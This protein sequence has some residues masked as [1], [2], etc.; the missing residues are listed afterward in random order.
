MNRYGKLAASFLSFALAGVPAAH[1]VNI[2]FTGNFNADD[3]VQLFNFSTDGASTVFLVSYGW[4]GGTQADGNVVSA[5]GLDTILTL[6]DA[7][8]NY[9]IA[10]DDGSGACFTAASG[11]AG[12]SGNV[13]EGTIYD[14]CLSSALSAGDYTVAV[15]QFDNFSNGGTLG[16]GFV[17]DGQ[18][19]FTGTAYG[20]SN[21]IFCSVSGTNRSSAWAYDILN[22]VSASVVDAPE[23][24]SVLL[25]GAGLVGMGVKKRRAS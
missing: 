25:L 5:G 1:A 20:C 7:G 19:N 13:D 3:N 12:S 15:T 4:G 9:V 17:R 21:G 24:L 14:T 6:F 22:V 23:P 8:G 18:G 2:S 11:I 16:A 10:N